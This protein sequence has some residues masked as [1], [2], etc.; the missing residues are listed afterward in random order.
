MLPSCL[1]RI[2]RQGQ[3][4][5]AGALCSLANDAA[6]PVQIAH[7]IARVEYRSRQLRSVR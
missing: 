5:T 6:D 2:R 3:H 1:P 7:R 4:V